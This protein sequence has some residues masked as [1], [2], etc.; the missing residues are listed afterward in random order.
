MQGCGYLYYR[1]VTSI[2]F[3]RNVILLK[4]IHTRNKFVFSLTACVQF[5]E[6]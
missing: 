2:V 3:E 5:D 1:S 6:L 4:I